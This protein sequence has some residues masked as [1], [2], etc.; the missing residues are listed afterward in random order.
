MTEIEMHIVD[1]HGLNQE[2]PMFNLG[3]EPPM[4]EMKQGWGTDGTQIRRRTAPRDSNYLRLQ[5]RDDP[6]HNVDITY[7]ISDICSRTV[8]DGDACIMPCS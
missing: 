2:R 7:C 8:S 5:Q 4:V 6:K 3:G 1:G